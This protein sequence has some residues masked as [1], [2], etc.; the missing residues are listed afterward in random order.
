MVQVNF[1]QIQY[2]TWILGILADTMKSGYESRGRGFESSPERHPLYNSIRSL[3][4]L[5]RRA[6]GIRNLIDD[7]V[8]QL[9]VA[10]FGHDADEWLGT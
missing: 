4:A 5:P 9:A 3:V 7:F 6:N 1:V 10:R 8:H 2:I